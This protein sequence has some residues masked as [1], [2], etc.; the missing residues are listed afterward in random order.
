MEHTISKGDVFILYALDVKGP[1][2]GGEIRDAIRELTDNEMNL[3]FTSIYSGIRRLLNIEFIEHAGKENPDGTGHTL[4]A[5]TEKGKRYLNDHLKKR[6]REE[7]ERLEEK[8]SKGS[9]L[10]GLQRL[11]GLSGA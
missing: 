4:Y 7:E 2:H 1:L 5:I 3:P 10:P 9:L 8:E 6:R 11:P